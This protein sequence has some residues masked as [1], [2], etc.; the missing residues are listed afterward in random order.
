MNSV[1]DNTPVMSE[2]AT[3][4]TAATAE[5]AREL[6]KA[7]QVMLDSARTADK[8]HD[9]LYDIESYI[10]VDRIE[11]LMNAQDGC[12]YFYCGCEMLFGRDVNPKSNKDAVTLE[13]IDSNQAHVADNCILAC[14]SCNSSKRHN[15][16]FDTMRLWAFPIKRG[17]AKWCNSC[18]TVKSVAQFGNN[19]ARHD[20]LDSMCSVCRAI[21]NAQ[22]RR[23]RKFSQIDESSPDEAGSVAE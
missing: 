19:K 3:E 5:K 18:K 1:V 15:V 2:I 13:R 23:K 7:A 16:P 4:V 21:Y 10:T 17:V 12:C 22:D 14:R 6:R 20:G 9:R 11:W 8:K